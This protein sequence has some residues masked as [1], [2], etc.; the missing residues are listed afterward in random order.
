MRIFP[1]RKPASE[2][3][4]NRA[5]FAIDLRPPSMPKKKKLRGPGRPPKPKVTRDSVTSGFF[6][7]VCIIDRFM[8][9]QRRD[10]DPGRRYH[11]IAKLAEILDIPRTTLTNDIERMQLDLDAPL[12]VIHERGGWGYTEDAAYLP[13][14]LLSEGDLT[15]LC[16]TWAALERRRN[17][18]WGDRV[19]PL[20][21]KLLGAMGHEFSLDFATIS[22]RIA[23]RGSGYQDAIEL[24]I[25]EQVASSVLDS[26]ELDFVYSKTREDGTPAPPEERRA[27]ARAIVCVDHAWYLITDDPLRPGKFRTFAICRMRSAKDTGIPFTPEA[28]LDLEEVLG[29]SLGIHTGGK[30]AEV[31]VRFH[32]SIARYV[33]EH[34]WHK[35]EK[36]STADDG[37]LR[38]TMRVAVNPEV[39]MKIQRW[40][41]KADVI[42]P[43]ELRDKFVQY[44]RE[45]ALTYLS[46]KELLELGAAV[47]KREAEGHGGAS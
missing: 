32:Q 33:Q 4:G 40:G 3:A 22:E 1:A 14:I 6:Q 24:P 21:E 25:F 17:S 12:D 11:S 29:D 35:S 7:R 2:L 26:N 43:A 34:F 23:F 19:R 16:A 31:E 20:M 27:K 5:F 44:A 18:A 47:A 36:F 41:P 30:V 13:N 9:E 8:R 10:P 39:E 42:A 46:S 15:I 45:D 37:R 28:R 38:L